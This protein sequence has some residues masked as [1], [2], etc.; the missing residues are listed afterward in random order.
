M[1]HFKA[2]EVTAV[3][4]YELFD[5]V[6]KNYTEANKDYIKEL[7][8]TALKEP[9]MTKQEV[10]DGLINWIVEAGCT[11]MNEHYRKFVFSAIAYL[12]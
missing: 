7:V 4:D 2:N 3:D 10:L 6:R 1:I 8:K 5:L 9:A 12:T 11:G